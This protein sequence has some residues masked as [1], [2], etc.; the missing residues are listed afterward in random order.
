MRSVLLQGYP[1]LEYIIL[2][3]G[4]TDNSVA[5]ITKYAPWLAFWESSRDDGQAASLAFGFS[6]ATGDIF[7]WINSDDV[8][9]E[10]AFADTVSTFQQSACDVV[11]GNMLL[12]DELG[13]TIG[14]RRLSPYILPL[15]RLGMIYGGYGIY[16]PSAF[17]TRCIY[18]SC[19]GVNPS[20]R[21]C[22][23]TDL[24]VRFAMNDAAFRFKRKFFTAYR[25]HSN[26]K[27]TNLRDVAIEERHR[28]TNSFP[29]LNLLQKRCIKALC[30]AWRLAYHLYHLEI[31]SIYSKLF[32]KFRWVP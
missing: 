12:V 30:W 2:D 13:N 4:S 19:G 18:N 10:N 1:N 20:F 23:D 29:P 15:C 11:F 14:E 3:G 32:G 24:V 25:V 9:F 6:K 21:F 8:Y 26:S 22:M 31:K 17:W 28:A 27:T 16:Q 7:A 5:I